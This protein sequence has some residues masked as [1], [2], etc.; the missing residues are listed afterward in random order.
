MRWET[1]GLE[2]LTPFSIAVHRARLFAPRSSL[3]QPCV[4]TRGL[5]RG[6]AIPRPRPPHQSSRLLADRPPSAPT[7]QAP[8]SGRNQD[9]CRSF[10]SARRGRDRSELSAYLPSGCVVSSG[11]QRGGPLGLCAVAGWRRVLLR[12]V[13]RGRAKGRLYVP[14][15]T[16][17]GASETNR[18]AGNRAGICAHPS[19]G[20]ATERGRQSV[21]Q[22]K[23]TGAFGRTTFSRIFRAW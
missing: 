17:K 1:S 8:T 13:L 11:A 6:G 15:Q 19:T 23:A 12:R 16:N 18:R 14:K 2:R 4:Q 22:Y 5:P 21:P 7:R 3:L 20:R 9:G 10:R